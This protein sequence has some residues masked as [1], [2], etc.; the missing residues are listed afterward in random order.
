[1]EFDIV[2]YI[3]IK[4]SFFFP[5]AQAVKMYYSHLS[6]CPSGPNWHVGVINIDPTCAKHQQ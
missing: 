2:K 6:V 3:F 5:V 4:L 1:M